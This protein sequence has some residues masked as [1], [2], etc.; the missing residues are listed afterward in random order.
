MNFENLKFHEQVNLFFL[1]CNFLKLLQEK[2]DTTISIIISYKFGITFFMFVLTFRLTMES[3]NSKYY[4]KL[5]KTNPVNFQKI[6]IL[7]KTK[8]ESDNK[9]GPS[10]KKSK[11]DDVPSCSADC[12]TPQPVTLHDNSTLQ[13]TEIVTER[14]TVS[15]ENST[16]VID[17]S[18]LA[19][20]EKTVADDLNDLRT[21]TSSLEYYQKKFL[22]F[23]TV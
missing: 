7:F 18:N 8:S 14:V 16:N 23:I 15:E 10:S 20:S 9:A 17:E 19:S 13:F 5:L 22:I 2:E 3:H 12:K 21:A 1:S 11:S 6:T 4:A